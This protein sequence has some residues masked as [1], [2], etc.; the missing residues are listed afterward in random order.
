ML[1]ACTVG[2]DE[3]ANWNEVEATIRKLTISLLGAAA[4]A[5]SILLVRQQKQM[6]PQDT[7]EAIPPGETTQAPVS[8]D[9]LRELGL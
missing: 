9:R 6:T 5:A 1:P 8:L 3:E 2:E 4:V 7:A